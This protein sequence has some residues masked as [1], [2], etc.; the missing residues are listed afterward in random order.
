M[1]VRRLLRPLLAAALL[2]AI[3]AQAFFIRGPEPV[4]EF[5]IQRVHLFYG[6]PGLGPNSHFHTADAS[7]A[8]VLDKPGMGWTFELL[9]RSATDGPVKRFAVDVGPTPGMVKPSAQCEDESINLGPCIAVN[10]LPVPAAWVSGNSADFGRPFFDITGMESQV[11]FVVSP[12]LGINAAKDV[13][14]Q[15]GLTGTYGIHVATG[16]RGPSGGSSVNPLYQFST[17][18]TPGEADTRFFPFDGAYE[19]DVEL[20]VSFNVFVKTIQVRSAGGSAFGHPTLELIDRRSGK[21][22][23]FTTLASWVRRSA[24]IPRTSG[25]SDCRRCRRRAASCRRIRGVGA[26][27]SN[28]G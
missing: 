24:R 22:V 16:S 25:H 11:T 9:H 20:S 10:N 13:F 23:Y 3:Q 12:G 7:Q 15:T 17:G 2:S 5:S 26:A 4:V 18:F 1:L 14:V 19:S 28:T 27:T 21:H 8:A 6:T